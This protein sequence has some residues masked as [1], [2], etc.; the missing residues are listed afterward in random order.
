MRAK[1]LRDVAS[2]LG[3]GDLSARAPTEPLDDETRADWQDDVDETD[4]K[5]I[6]ALARN[7]HDVSKADV[8]AKFGQGRVMSAAKGLAAGM[9]DSIR[10]FEQL[11]G[12]L[13]GSGG[14][15]SSQAVAMEVQRMR[16]AA[17]EREM[18]L[19]TA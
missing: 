13:T 16:H 9:I 3:V 2:E 19:A 18:R 11:M 17:R 6:A 8:R 15:S 7:R 12:Q 4:A 1:Q 10:T 14:A 5:F